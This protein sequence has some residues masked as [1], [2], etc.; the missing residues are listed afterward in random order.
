MFILKLYS[1]SMPSPCVA[2]SL[3]TVPLTCGIEPLA[4][5]HEPY[6][7]NRFLFFV[8]FLSPFEV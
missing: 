3:S 7:H 8:D 5:I 4:L 2:F 6:L 1:C